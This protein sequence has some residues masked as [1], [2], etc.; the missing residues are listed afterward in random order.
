[1]ARQPIASADAD[2]A[3]LLDERLAARFDDLSRTEQLVA[4]YFAE[5]PADV[6]LRS[7]IEIGRQLQTSD[8]T[9]IRTALAL[10][11]ACLPEL[12]RQLAAR[13][14]AHARPAALL[15]RS[16][17]TIGDQPEAALDHVLSSEIEFL[18]AMRRT[19]D[20]AMFSRAIWLLDAA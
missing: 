14:R 7:A 10:V 4:H 2:T 1:M 20:Q 17:E 12:K 9:V 5:H 6:A 8:A 15:D 18:G 3:P 16:L 13:L 11:Y 19:V